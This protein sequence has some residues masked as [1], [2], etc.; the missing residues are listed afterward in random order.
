M[1]RKIRL[2]KNRDTL[3]HPGGEEG[4]V[5]LLVLWVLALISV[6]VLGWAQEWRTELKLAANF[7]EGHQ[8]RRLAEAGVYY[9]LGKLVEAR[10]AELARQTAA[11][12]DSQIIPSGIWQGDQSTFTLSL[13]GGQVKIRVEDEGGKI[14]LN[15]ATEPVLTKLFLGLGFG[16]TRVRTMV[17][18]L[19]DWRGRE[20]VARPYGAKDSYYLSLDP[21]YPARKARFEV[22]QELSWVRGFEGLALLPRLGEWLTVQETGTGINVNTAPL[23]VLLALGLP[24]DLASTLILN[25]QTLPLSL[26]DLRQMSDPKFSQTL[27]FLGSPFFTIKSTGMVNNRSRHTIKAAVS[28]DPSGEN[29]WEIFSWADDVPA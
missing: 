25:R 12:Q 16:E 27:G 21:P 14:N 10:V 13:P 3:A 5:L 6:V 19:L 22:V 24:P 9:A 26:Q 29:P 23:E 17:D 18:S 4:V 15:R 2:P 7:R 1:W 11:T 28:V 20:N 8:S